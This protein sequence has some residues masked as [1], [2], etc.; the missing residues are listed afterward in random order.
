MGAR[1]RRINK[2]RPRVLDRFDQ[3]TCAESTEKTF[4]NN[5][6]TSKVVILARGLGTRMRRAD[7][8]AELAGD[9]AAAAE[10]GVKA[11]I[12]IGRPFLD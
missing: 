7:A 10:L 6:F 4:L 8:S 2:L 12:P 3:H 5:S 11:L 9:Q 1:V